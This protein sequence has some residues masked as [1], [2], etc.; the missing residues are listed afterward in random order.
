MTDFINDAGYRTKEYTS[1]RGRKHG[2]SKFYRTN[3]TSILQNPVYIGKIKYKEA[4]HQGQHE[5]ILDENLWDEVKVALEKNLPKKTNFRMKTKH[6]FILQGLVRCG[7][8]GSHMT[9]K[10]ST[11]RSKLHFYYQCAMNSHFGKKE[12]DMRYV[13][14][15]ELERVVLERLKELSVDDNTI[16]QIVEK[17]NGLSG[18]EIQQL[19][20]H[21]IGMENQMKPVELQIKNLVDG[22]AQGLKISESVLG[23]LKELEEQKKQLETQTSRLRLDLR[24]MKQKRLDAQ[25]MRDSLIHFSQILEAA[26]PEEQKALVPRIVESITFTP[27]EIEIA[28]FDQMIE[29]GL[30]Y[31]TPT[32]NHFSNGAL[33]MSKWLP[34]LDSNQRQ[35][36]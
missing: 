10:Y 11:G 9:P 13:P 32:V 21:V 7:S 20:S 23:R 2:N 22:L 36:G 19:E 16:K 4:V 3:V 29:R 28:L 6:I 27:T 8:C 14:A 34:R 17:A 33:E 25:T 12:C 35:D 1:R 15:V 30:L 18:E 5:A 31:P 26:A 24:Q